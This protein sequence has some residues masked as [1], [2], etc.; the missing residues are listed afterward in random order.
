MIQLSHFKDKTIAVLGLGKSGSAAALA[1]KA[2]GAEVWAWDDHAGTRS[3]AAAKGIP[4]VDLY[5]C[6]W[7]APEC[8]VLSPGIPHDKPA[9]H[10]LTL[11]A[12]RAG[13]EIIGDMELLGRTG[14]KVRVL[15]ITGTNGKS[16]TTALIGHILTQAGHRV[17][18]G[19]NIGTPVL[20]LESLDEAGFYVLEMSS[21]QLETTSSLRSEVA[22]LL[23]ISPDHLERHDGMEGYIAA[24]RRIF[25]G[26]AKPKTVVVGVEDATCR[27]LYDE[28]RSDGQAV[29]AISGS[30]EVA[31]G[32]YVL[33]GRLIDDLEAKRQP[34]LDLRGLARLPGPHNWQNAAAAYAS[35]RCLGLAVEDIAAGLKSF[36][37]LS[38]RQELLAVIDGI[39]YVNDS[40]AT[41]P[42]AAAKALACYK[43]IFWIAGG[44]AKD[45][46]LAELE[47]HLSQV[48]HA[49]LIGEA[50]N[51]FAEALQGHTDFTLCGD[52]TRAVAAAQKDAKAALD[53][54][55]RPT[56]VVLLSP[57]CA[58]FDHYRNF[59]VR[60]DAFRE[61]VAALPGTR[62]GLAT[63]SDLLGV[64][65]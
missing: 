3:A 18:V 19:G 41:N 44:R 55:A 46:E 25:D 31:G 24:K 29:I 63:P 57:A 27:S 45:A 52:L 2:G 23:N 11:L 65:A 47:P 15:G 30:D 16:T 4:L 38:H 22:I 10:P 20:A 34:V 48:V 13:C 1:L 36:P 26:T 60:G 43:R 50:Q 5:G 9:P 12:R 51:L 8:L 64:G 14:L 17:Q 42:D 40:K 6:D 53:R 37:G 7:Q 56:P 62:G 58:S 28:L 49:F 35:C 59:E 54:E 39:A 61:L 21:Y 32:V 33:D